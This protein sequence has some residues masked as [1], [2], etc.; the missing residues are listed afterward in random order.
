[1]TIT[2]IDLRTFIDI[3]YFK[4]RNKAFKRP[5]STPVLIL[6]ILYVLYDTFLIFLY[7][8]INIRKRAMTAIAMPNATYYNNITESEHVCL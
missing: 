4:N 5:E 2:I 3:F 7:V 8:L 1:M 6:M